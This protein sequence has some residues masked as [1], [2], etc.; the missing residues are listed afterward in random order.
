M[1]TEIR[2]FNLMF[3]FICS[4]TGQCATELKEMKNATCTCKAQLAAEVAQAKS[5][6]TTPEIKESV[7][8]MGSR[9][10]K[11]KGRQEGGCDDDEDKENDEHQRKSPFCPRAD[12]KA[13]APAA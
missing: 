5:D 12:A 11:S 9:A 2:R 6:C 4:K 8:R 1:C 3:A 13:K 7:D 10:G